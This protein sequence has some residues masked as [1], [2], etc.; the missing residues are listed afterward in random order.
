MNENNI[1]SYSFMSALLSGNG[2]IYTYVYLPL[3]KRAVTKA[4]SE[5]KNQMT[6]DDLIYTMDQLYGLTIPV[7]IASKLLQMVD[8]DASRKKRTEFGLSYDKTLHVLNFKGYTYRDK[9]NIYDSERRN[10]ENLQYEFE[11]YMGRENPE[12]EDYPSFSEFIDQNKRSLSA[13]FSG[14]KS[15]F[16]DLTERSYLPHVRFLKHIEK[17]KDYLYKTAK[18]IY[19]GTLMATFLEDEIDLSE[20]MLDKTKFF[21]DTQLVLEALDL[22]EADRTKPAK[23]LMRLIQGS[24]NYV[25]ILDVTLDEIRNILQISTSRFSTDGVDKVVD[26]CKRNGRT[27]QWLNKLSANLEE[28]IKNELQIEVVPCSQKEKN[29]FLSTEEF[30]KLSKRWAKGN[31]AKHDTIAYMYVRAR[32]NNN[33]TSIQKAGYWFVTANEDLYNFNAEERPDVGLP[34]IATPGYLTGILFIG[35]PSKA[36]NSVSHLMLSESI[37]QVILAETPDVDIIKEFENVVSQLELVTPNEYVLLREALSFKSRKVLCEYLS[38]Q[39]KLPDVTKTMIETARDRKEENEALKAVLA[40]NKIKNKIFVS[41]IILLIGLILTFA[42]KTFCSTT[43]DGFIFIGAITLLIIVLLW[44]GKIAS[45]KIKAF[46][47]AIP[48]LGGLWGFFNFMINLGKT[49]N[50]TSLL[51]K[52]CD[53]IKGIF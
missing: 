32:R 46:M 48:S 47:I 34:E 24:N 25:R 18:N 20:K 29:D 17:C 26:A 50:I 21:F 23:D 6:C 30:K 27:I 43:Y 15:E 7:T 22:Q 39:Q 2:D 49:L 5:G 45:K 35:N 40:K 10:V 11:Q 12:L 52:F 51:T 8:K 53:F 42:Y 28:R 16:L 38:D 9:E 33:T 13:F 14:K 31:R 37:A 44:I 4:A 19:L 36:A 41:V 3:V 1:V